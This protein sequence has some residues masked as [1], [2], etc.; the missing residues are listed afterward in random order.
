MILFRYFAREVF[1]TMFA[2]AGIVLVVGGI[3]LLLGGA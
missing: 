1:L 3:W 2:V